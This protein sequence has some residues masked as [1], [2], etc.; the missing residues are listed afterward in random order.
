MLQHLLP[1]L[2]TTGIRPRKLPSQTSMQLAA[3]AALRTA[4]AGPGQLLSPAVQLAA[5]SHPHSAAYQL[6]RSRAA[7]AVLRE[8]SCQ[9]HGLSYSFL[10]APPQNACACL[11]NRQ[12]PLQAPGWGGDVI[13][14]TQLSILQLLQIIVF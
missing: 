11:R 3:N 4:A 9:K 1:L 5:P 2:Q 7:H 6:S 10:S 12:Q 14:W 8:P 13:P